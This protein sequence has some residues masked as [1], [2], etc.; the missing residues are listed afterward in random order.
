[1]P[2]KKI[3]PLGN[4]ENSRNVSNLHYNITNKKQAAE[5]K[6]SVSENSTKPE[7][8]SPSSIPFINSTILPQDATE[9]SSVSQSV[10]RACEQSPGNSTDTTAVAGAKVITEA[11]CCHV[12]MTDSDDNYHPIAEAQ[13]DS[14]ATTILTTTSTACRSIDYI[15][16]SAQS[17]Q[18]MRSDT[19]SL[20]PSGRPSMETMMAQWEFMRDQFLGSSDE[21]LEWLMLSKTGGVE[22]YKHATRKTQLAEDQYFKSLFEIDL[23]EAKRKLISQDLAPVLKGLS[24]VRNVESNLKRLQKLYTSH[25]QGICSQQLST[26]IDH[27]LAN[28]EQLNLLELT[29]KAYEEEMKILSERLHRSQTASEECLGEMEK[30]SEREKNTTA[31][32]EAL[33]AADVLWM[34]T[35]QTANERALADMRELIPS[36]I[37]QLSVSDLTNILRD[38]GG[39]Y[40]H[41][42]CAELKKNKLLQLV[43]M[44]TDDIAKLN[45]LMGDSKQYFLDMDLDVVEMRA[46]RTCLPDVFEL[47]KDGRKAE[48]RER[49]IAQ[50]KQLVA[51]ENGDFVK[52][53]WDSDAGKRVQV[54]L[55]AL[56]AV[57]QRRPVY[58]YETPQQLQN[59]LARY[60]KQ[61]TLLAAKK[62]LLNEIELE[63]VDFK[64]EYNTILSESRNP[65]YQQHYG[66]RALAQAKENAK[67]DLAKSEKKKKTVMADISRIEASI[68][69]ASMTKDDVL[70]YITDH[71]QFVPDW[72]T[73]KDIPVPIKGVFDRHPVIHRAAKASAVFVTAEEEAASRKSELLLL[74]KRPSNVTT[75]SS[76]VSIVGDEDS[77]LVMN[78]E[79]TESDSKLMGRKKVHVNSSTLL[80]LNV[81]FQKETQRTI[82]NNSKPTIT[83]IR[84]VKSKN[85]QVLMGYPDLLL[86]LF[87]LY[88]LHSS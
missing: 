8:L 33:L 45:F 59:Q 23:L 49:F 48:W 38:K 74:Q 80:T 83:N 9:M 68:K 63:H 24:N 25:L 54:R 42:L 19:Q 50:L 66:T 3:R 30:W 21:A 31:Y 84:P 52:G 71:K 87:P 69:S 22:A 85:L 15:Q 79:S 37:S 29:V 62:Q 20:L 44:H 51:R 86:S 77:N 14:G 73:S 2:K 67:E 7:I 32:R 64:M 46:I 11:R 5:D 60:E 65:V 10:D 75:P 47:D 1:M 27:F 40:S 70:Q 4:K 61:E 36:N 39:F 26:Q 17:L 12:N 88:K 43:V 41:G 13:Y 6:D 76:L 16:P 35:Q 81:M 56:R 55:P 34:K 53:G 28:S 57:E 78:A 82:K 58:F 18:A 72:E